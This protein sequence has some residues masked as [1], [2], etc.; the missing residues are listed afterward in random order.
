MG[1]RKRLCNEEGWGV[2]VNCR[3]ASSVVAD[4]KLHLGGKG[5]DGLM[6]LLLLLELLLFKFRQLRVQ[7]LIGLTQ[8]SLQKF[9]QINVQT[10]IRCTHLLLQISGQAPI[11]CTR[12]AHLCAQLLILL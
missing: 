5:R 4:K 2:S 10:P 12:P 9:L 7:A 3:G 1:W 11:G 8:L 6:L